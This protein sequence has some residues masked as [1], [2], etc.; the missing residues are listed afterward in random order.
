MSFYSQF[1][2]GFSTLGTQNKKVAFVGAN[3]LNAAAG[4]ALRS[5]GFVDVVIYYTIDFTPQ[6]FDNKFANRFYHWL[7]L[8]CSELSNE[9]WNVSPRI[10]EGRR[11]YHNLIL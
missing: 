11:T 2:G 3:P 10:N 1:I 6:R 4:L 5:I 7:D 8:K 9:T